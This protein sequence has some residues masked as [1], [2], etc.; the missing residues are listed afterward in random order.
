MRP[1]WTFQK[2]LFFAAVIGAAMFLSFLIDDSLGLGWP[3]NVVRNWQEFGLINLHG[4]LAY[5]AGGFG[6]PEHLQ[7]YKGMSPVCLYLPYVVTK[8]FSW[9]GLDTLSFYILLALAVSWASWDLLGKDGFAMV[10]A[11]AAIFCPGYMRWLRMLDPNTVSVLPVLPY[12]VIALAILR[13]PKFTPA[14][15]VALILLTLAYMPLN[16]TTAWMCGPLIFFLLGKASLNRRGLSTL[17]AVM[18]IGVPAMAA[19]SFA[20]KTGGH[21]GGGRIDPIRV[22]AGYTWGNGGYGE[23][24]TTGRAFVRLAFTNGIG[25]LPLWLAVVYAMTQRLRSGVRMT[26]LMFAPLALA[27]ANMVIMRNYFGHHPWMAG[28]VLLCGI[29]FSLGL[30]REGLEDGA[31]TVSEKIPFKWVIRTTLLCFGYSLAVLLFFRANETNMLA[32]EKLVRQHTARSDTLVI[33]KDS[34]SA[35]AALADRLDEPLDRHMMVLNSTNDLAGQEGHWVILSSVKMDGPLTLT[36]ESNV[37]SSSRL[38]QVSDWFNHSISRRSAGDRL[39]LA[40]KYFLY[41]A[42]R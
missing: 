6:V 22:L 26:W 4:Q 37:S 3:T 29:I 15:A 27:V 12:A 36:A 23:G 41:E 25:L 7:L 21:A 34:D 11:A 8:I 10:V 30:L 24:L 19:V 17:I 13:K 20:A 35:T 18:V 1:A 14:L 31:T 39:E 42:A 28:P 2:G 32:L 9:T 38:N 40:E 5:N 33:L 16:W